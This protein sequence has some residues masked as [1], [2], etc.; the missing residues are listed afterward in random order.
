MARNSMVSNGHPTSWRRGSRPCAGP[1]ATT[2]TNLS[3]RRNYET[4]S[5]TQ[6]TICKHYLKNRLRSYLTYRICHQPCD[7]LL[8]H[9]PRALLPCSPRY[10][11]CRAA[12]PHI[13]S[14]SRHRR[15]HYIPFTCCPTACRLPHSWG[16]ARAGHRRTP[17]DIRPFHRPYH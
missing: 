15:P 6:C 9:Q 5:T 10:I 1:W 12:W 4:V 8:Y 13:R 16:S 7:R 3:K 2:H 14:H 11:R 17:Y